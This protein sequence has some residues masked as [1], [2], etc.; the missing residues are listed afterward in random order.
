[1]QNDQGFLVVFFGTR[2]SQCSLQCR[3]SL[4]INEDCRLIQGFLGGKSVGCGRDGRNLVY[5]AFTFFE[6]ERLLEYVRLVCGPQAAFAILALTVR[7][8]F[9]LV[10]SC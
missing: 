2:L 8:V 3:F 10:R 1:M 7:R 6:D 5:I 4:L 9:Q